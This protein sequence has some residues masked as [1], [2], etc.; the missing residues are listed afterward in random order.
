[1]LCVLLS[2]RTRITTGSQKLKECFVIRRYKAEDYK[3]FGYTITA[4]RSNKKL[5]VLES[6]MIICHVCD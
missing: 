4:F 1:M 3:D 5:G 6:N 2:I